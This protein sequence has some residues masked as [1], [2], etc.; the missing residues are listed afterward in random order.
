[1][2]SQAPGSRIRGDNH[3]GEPADAT[4][5]NTPE[6]SLQE[7][8]HSPCYYLADIAA[9]PHLNAIWTTI[10]TR[11]ENKA[12]KVETEHYSNVT[13]KRNTNK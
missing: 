6:I 7:L 1:M 8:Y 13:G 11:V 2:A 10:A 9:I 5:L 4:A 3:R 12:I